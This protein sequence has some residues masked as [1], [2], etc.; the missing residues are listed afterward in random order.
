M[1]FRPALPVPNFSVSF[2]CFVHEYSSLLSKHN[3]SLQAA[4]TT[5]RINFIFSSCPCITTLSFMSTNIE[6][7]RRNKVH[8]FNL[9]PEADLFPALHGSG[10]Q[11]PEETQPLPSCLLI[12]WKRGP[13]QCARNR[14][15][16]NQ[17]I[18][19]GGES[20]SSQ[21]MPYF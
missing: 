21:N 7:Q 11:A 5:A 15:V 18:Q 20:I 2:Q 17:L 12:H 3:F 16:Y 14:Q 13:A 9:P 19:Q 10:M 8:I 6:I 1:S 4:R